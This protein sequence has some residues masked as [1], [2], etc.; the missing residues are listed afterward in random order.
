MLGLDH[1]CIILSID[2]GKVSGWA[3]FDCG[4]LVEYG[5]ARRLSERQDAVRMAV[6]L[7]AERGLPLIVCAER[8]TAGGWGKSAKGGKKNQGMTK[9]LLGLGAAW[10]KWEDV[11]ED[12]EVPKRCVVRFPPQTWR[13][14][15]LGNGAMRSEHAK[16]VAV[17]Y[18]E[19]RFKVVVKHDV[20][21]GICIGCCGARAP[22]VGDVLAGKK[23]TRK[24]RNRR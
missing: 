5:E 17:G 9:T 19:M 12:H 6:E 8:W 16:K 3:I 7:A 22:E 2:A 13:A 14:R 21:E 24:R 1:E 15:V 10:G 23:K 18:V 11:L 20:A 4:K